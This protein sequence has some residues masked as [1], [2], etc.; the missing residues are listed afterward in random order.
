MKRP[1]A[2]RNFCLPALLFLIQMARAAENFDATTEIVGRITNGLVTPVNQLVTPAGVQVEL[3]GV[4]PNALALSPDGK[5]LA[6]S[7]LTNKLVV[8]NPAAGKISQIVAFPPDKVLADASAADE[9][10]STNKKAQLSLTGLAFSPDGSRIYL[11]NVNGDIKVFGVG[12]IETVAPL[13]S[14]ALPPANAVKRTNEIPAGI[15]VSR[16]GKKIYVAGNLSNRLFEFDA[17]TGDILRT[18]DVGVAPY[19]V[20]LCKKKIYVSNWGGRR[21]DASSVTG[22]AGHGTLVRVE[23]RSI[24][25]EGSVSV[26]DLEKT[27]QNEIVTGLHACA[28]ALS[29]DGKFVVAA[30]AG[31][32]TLSVIDTR[33][34]KIVETIWARQNPGDPFGAQPDALAFDKSGKK[35]FA[36]NGTQNAVAFFQFKPAASKLLGLIPAGW[37]PGA[38]AFDSK[39][40]AIEV[41]NIKSNGATM[42]NP[43]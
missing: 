36:C 19:D 17:A 13:L 31:S 28:L 34:D 16:D 1:A 43:R 3:P 14:I 6:T 38:F 23:D 12:K 21:P 41:A 15:A 9:N 11:A 20:V 32:D 42:E 7:G 18:W 22:P 4:R 26:I 24:A 29:P 33:S 39:R 27:N 35:L 5:I 25:S 10:L 37:F 30:N 8:I 40:K 2:V